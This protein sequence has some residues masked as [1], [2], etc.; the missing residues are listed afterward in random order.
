MT[1]LAQ[2]RPDGLAGDAAHDLA[3]QEA[4]MV[5]VIGGVR[6]DLPQRL[7]L[8]ERFD[9]RFA[10]EHRA[11]PERIRGQ[12]RHGRGVVEKMPD[13]RL[14]L[15]VPPVL[16]PV[17]VTRSFGSTSPRSISMLK[18]IA[19]MPLATDI[20]QTVVG[21]SHGVFW[22]DRAS[23]PTC[24]RPFAVE[25]DRAGGADLVLDFEVLD[26]RVDDGPVLGRVRAGEVIRRA[27]RLDLRAEIHWVAS[28]YRSRK[29]LRT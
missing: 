20:M 12:H 5:D 27:A 9:D 17:Q 15:A 28:L 18:Q 6:A 14:L 16:G 13:E 21:A 3:E 26:E 7:L 23:R 2:E 25:H 11:R 4:L 24:R 19:V 1:S 29:R 22:R 10:I 8:L